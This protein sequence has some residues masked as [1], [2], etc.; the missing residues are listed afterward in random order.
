[1]KRLRYFSLIGLLLILAITGTQAFAECNQ[2]GTNSWVCDGTFSGNSYGFSDGND[3]VVFPSGTIFTGY[4][5]D[6]DGGDD[7]IVNDGIIYGIVGGELDGLDPHGNDTLINNG[8]VIYCPNNGCGAGILG[9]SG[10]DTLINNGIVQDQFDGGPNNDLVINRGTV[11]Q[12]ALPGDMEGDGMPGVSYS[13]MPCE[14][15]DPGDDTLINSGTVTGSMLGGCGNDTLVLEPGANGGSDNYLLLDG[16]K[17]DDTL[18]LSFNNADVDAAV[19]ANASSGTITIDGQTFE[20]VN[21]EHVVKGEAEDGRLNGGVENNA[22]TAAVYCSEYEDGG[23]IV[24][25]IDENA[26]GYLLFS[27]SSEDAHAALQAAH[28]GG[29]HVMIAEEDGQSLWALTSNELQI[30]A[31]NGEYDFIFSPTI[32]GIPLAN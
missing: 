26:E 21:F 17:G 27:V 10:N 7:T 4:E 1:M 30:H 22:R 6:G 15:A 23:V 32:C 12:G 3:Y 29:E 9:Y 13:F 19:A 2:T 24:Y 5:V 14:M 16:E 11:L 8:S 20:W 28:D 31:A 18:V 25:G